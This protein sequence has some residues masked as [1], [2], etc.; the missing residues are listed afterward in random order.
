MLLGMTEAKDKQ[1][2]LALIPCARSCHIFRRHPR[3]CGDPSPQGGAARH[4]APL[5]LARDDSGGCDRGFCLAAAFASRSPE[6]TAAQPARLVAREAVIRQ[7][8][9]GDP[10]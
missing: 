2:S 6:R 9:I 3:A 10:G 1:M 8:L 4:F 5:Q 7:H